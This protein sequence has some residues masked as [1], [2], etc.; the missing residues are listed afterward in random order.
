MINGEVGGGAGGTLTSR[1]GT[2]SSQ[3]SP[4]AL[5]VAA[6]KD[7]AT[8]ATALLQKVLSSGQPAEVRQRSSA[9]RKIKSLLAEFLTWFYCF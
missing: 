7:D 8:G 6:R 4:P 5:H 3:R 2:R 9:V 1:T